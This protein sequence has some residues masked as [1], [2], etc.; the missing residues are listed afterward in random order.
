MKRAYCGSG[1]LTLASGPLCRTDI[2]AIAS[3]SRVALGRLVQRGVTATFWACSTLD[4]Q[5]C[6]VLLES[7]AAVRNSY[8]ASPTFAHEA[9]K[10]ATIKIGLS[11]YLRTFSDSRPARQSESPMTIR[12]RILFG[13][14]IGYGQPPASG[15]YLC[16]AVTIHDTA[17]I[18]AY[19]LPPA[20][21]QNRNCLHDAAYRFATL[22][23]GRLVKP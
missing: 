22:I 12:A 10:V 9:A 1:I 19:Y 16:L 13:R 23:S 6:W 18:G 5:E 3:S 21:Y 2:S 4:K 11:K 14:S 20:P 15:C 17:R 8:F 7:F